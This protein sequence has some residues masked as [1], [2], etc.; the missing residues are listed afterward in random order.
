MTATQLQ[1]DAAIDLTLLI[2]IVVAAVIVS[3]VIVVSIT[4]CIVKC[5]C[6][7]SR[8]RTSRAVDQTVVC[9]REGHEGLAHSAKTQTGTK[10]QTE[11]RN[12]NT[13]ILEPKCEFYPQYE[14]QSEWTTTLT[15]EK[16]P[17][18][19]LLLPTRLP[20]R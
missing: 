19:V 11:G 2:I 9:N 3:V 8:S 16:R 4:L 12:R 5:N 15:S 7:Q 20:K 1:P 10:Q 18:S 13:Q 17:P 14:S 6:G